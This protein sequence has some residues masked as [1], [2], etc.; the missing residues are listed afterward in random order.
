MVVKRFGRLPVAQ[1]T[2]VR[3]P[4]GA[5][6]EEIYFLAAF[7]CLGVLVHCKQPVQS[8]KSQVVACVSCNCYTDL[9]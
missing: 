6:K 7:Q 1:K 9:K 4:V 8:A 3:F 5:Q 2:W